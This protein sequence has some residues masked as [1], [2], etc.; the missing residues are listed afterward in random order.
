MRKGVLIAFLILSGMLASVQTIWAA[1]LSVTGKAKVLNTDAYLDFDANG[2]NVMISSTTGDFSGYVFSDDVGWIAFGTTDNAEGPVNINTTTGVV[3]GKAKVLNTGAYLDFGANNSDV[4]ATIPQGVFSGY[5]FSDDVGWINFGDTG[6]STSSSFDNTAPSISLTALSPDPN[7]DTTPTL[8]GTATEAIG[9]VSNVQYQMDSIAGSWTACTAD[10]AAFDE[11]SETFT[12]TPASALSQGS[13]TMYVQATDSNG[14]TTSGGSESSD[15]FTTD[16]VA[17]TIS[18][19][20]LSPDPSSDNTPTLSGTAT[21]ATTV[22]TAIQYQVDSTSGSWT[23]CTA[24]DGTIDETSETFSCTPGTALA[25]GAHTI[26]VRAT[27]S[28]TN[29]TALANYGSDA[30]TIDTT[31]PSLSLTAISPDPGTDT[32][33]TLTGTATDA[34]STV[35]SV[36]Y[37]IDST[38]GTWLDCAA[39]DSGDTAFDE[40]SE[41]FTCTITTALADGEHTIYVRATDFVSN[42][43]SSAT[44]SFTIDSTAPKSFDLDSPADGS[45][46]SSDRPTFKWKAA[47][48]LDA[49]SGLS[50]YKLEVY[51]VKDTATAVLESTADFN[52]RNS[53][54]GFTIDDI[55]V[56]RTTVYE[57]SLYKITYTNFSDT[58]AT[59]NYISVE[60]KSSSS[61][62]SSKN[63]GKLKQGKYTWKITSEDNAGNTTS[64][65]KD[66]MVDLTNPSL[67]GSSVSSSDALGE[68]DDYELISN[69]K[70][71]ITGTLTDNFAISKVDFSFYKQNYFLGIETGQTLYTLETLNY[72]NT[73]NTTNTI[74][75]PVVSWSFSFSPS[76]SLDYGK[77]SL[78]VK[79]YDKAGNSYEQTIPVYLLSENKAKE[80]L[81]KDKE[82]NKDILDKLKEESQVSL[83]SLEKKAV[84]RREKEAEELNTLTSTISNTLSSLF[85]SGKNGVTNVLALVTNFFTDT[86]KNT[87]NTANSIAVF[88]QNT[89]GLVIA[90]VQERITVTGYAVNLALSS[91]GSAVNN[92]IAAVFTFTTDFLASL[93]QPARQ[94]VKITLV[95][96]FTPLNNA[97]IGSQERAKEE[98][99][100]GANQAA[101]DIREMSEA[102]GQFLTEAGN[103]TIQTTTQLSQQATKLMVGVIVD[104]VDQ[105]GQAFNEANQTLAS[106]QEKVKEE[107]VKANKGTDKSLKKINE[108]FSLA[109]LSARKPVDNS[110]NFIERAKLWLLTF[111][112]VVLDPAPTQISEVMIEEIGSNYAIVSWKTNHYA[113]GKVNYG[114]DLSYGKGVLLSEREKYHQAKLTNLEP[115]KKYFFEVMSQNKNYVYDAFY[116][117]EIPVK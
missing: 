82:A 63:D 43:S 39:D 97:L 36:K 62:S 103:G 30:F 3:T 72:T 14:N 55:P 20:A 51:A 45:Y 54:S 1:T 31:A 70:P 116:T 110:A 71:T 98:M 21:D 6:V 80:L 91:L 5:V 117:F 44:D 109:M 28:S 96:P 64:S 114:Q 13:H 18:L 53:S 29:T 89:A 25:D 111:E 35:S 94:T 26:Y 40:A 57:T 87:A 100:K 37:Q 52:T 107:I 84:L 60:T 50:K 113:W 27:D 105:I 11:A 65:S 24:S 42:T 32:T 93:P 67:T 66:F 85:N 4:S 81:L 99:R 19:T 47:S 8:S 59:N 48:T 23:T 73:T 7:N 104:G 17:P 22:L 68:V 88:A 108:G 16:S 34:T 46:T 83:P 75:S 2:S 38:S 79:G 78:V 15:A 10:D 69:T 115:G 74:S 33:P 41:A 92:F 61:W 112:S 58:D 102:A 106:S 101:K 90:L 77:Y 86:A 56:S 76:A 49:T 9:T 95:N 12:C